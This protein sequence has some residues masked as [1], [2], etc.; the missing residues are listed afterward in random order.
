MHDRT[1]SRS[2]TTMPIAL[3]LLA[4][5]GQGPEDE[6]RG[7]TTNVTLSGGD[8]G[9]D[10]SSEIAVDVDPRRSL[11]ETS[12]S[13]LALFTMTETLSALATNDGQPADPDG[14]HDQLI[15][16]YAE[17]PGLGLG[18]HCD[19][20]LDADG[21]PILNGYPIACPRNEQS[22]IGTIEDWTPIA[23]VNRFDLAPSDGSNCGEARLVFANSH[24][25]IDRVLL[26]FEAKIPNPDPSCGL[27]ACVPV[28]EFWASLSNTKPG[29]RAEL[30]H[31]AYVTGHPKLQA[32][33]FGPFI[34]ASNFGIGA[35]QIRTNNFSDPS[36]LW[37]LREFKIV[38]AK[39]SIDPFEGAVDAERAR[40][41]LR[42]V[43]VPV[44]AN[45]F[46][47]L[48]DEGAQNTAGAAC[49]DAFVQQS[50]PLLMTDDVN[51]MAVDMPTECLAAESIADGQNRYDT[52]LVPGGAFEA[53]IEARIAQLDPA[54]TLDAVDITRRAAFAGACIGCHQEATG[55][56]LGNGVISPNSGFFVHTDEFFDSDDCGDGSFDCFLISDAVRNTFLPHRE[57]VMETFL[58]SGPCCS[59]I[60]LDEG[61]GD[62]QPLD[63]VA[64][65]EL[66]DASPEAVAE[67]EA[68]ADAAV[69]LETVGGGSTRRAH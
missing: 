29:K 28:Q 37:T 69:T 15:D 38:S 54:S 68:V 1:R 17:G 27:D 56:D 43:E 65:V 34:R 45:P 25:A 58:S 31:Q 35:G 36:F 32:A 4:A 49:R 10:G 20:V 64:L 50:V 66:D 30:L 61:F 67:A 8:D 60:L 48:F 13:A 57:R 44:A 40:P 11:F 19:D 12:R 41:R 59:P 3:A 6:F 55:I 26:I 14:L 47:P 42:A 62:A 18:G 22:R 33:G 16:T 9:C 24:S 51:I 63:P 39:R 52:Q 7:Y 23:A 53:A 2:T 21:N 5:C 46:G